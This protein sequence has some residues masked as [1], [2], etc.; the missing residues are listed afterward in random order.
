MIEGGCLCGAVRYAIAG[1]LADIQVCHCRSC[2]KAQGTAFATNIPVAR[3]CFEWR[4]GQAEICDYESSPGKH[5]LF[6]GRCGSPLISRRDD[7]PDAARVR[8]GTLDAPVHARIASQAFVAETPCWWP[9]AA[10]VVCFD[11]ARSETGG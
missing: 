9:P 11:G 1:A 6:C 3:D 10:D 2:Q 7:A 5:R 8:A 4:R